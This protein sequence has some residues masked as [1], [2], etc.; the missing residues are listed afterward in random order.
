MSS[1]LVRA[2]DSKRRAI[3]ENAVRVRARAWQE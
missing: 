2:E 1:S 3:E